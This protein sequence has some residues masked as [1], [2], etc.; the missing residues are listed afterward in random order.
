MSKLSK[1]SRENGGAIAS[2][3]SLL[4]VVLLCAIIYF[5]RHPIMR[6]SAEQWVID[7]PAGHA[8]AIILLG[9]DNFFADRATHAAELFRQEVA[10]LV[11]AS[12]R[13]LRPSAGI[14]E[15]L[16]HDLIER[17]VGKENILRFPQDSES[18][19]DQAGPLS[20]L[21][22]ERGWKSVVIVTSN[23]DTRRTRYIFQK[24]FPP[25]IAVRVSSARDGDFDTENWW[26]KRLSTKLF[27]TEVVGM[28]AALWELRNVGAPK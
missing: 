10:P 9:D 19:L 14:A 21:A 1:T 4:F 12:G 28:A 7:E 26:T 5:A 27:V 23:Y 22:K 8:G 16:E 6:F 18:T 15:L 24:S 25:G 3:I 20:R 11:V 13:K 2:L 17:G